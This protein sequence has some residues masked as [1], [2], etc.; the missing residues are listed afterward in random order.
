MIATAGRTAAAAGSVVAPA[1]AG[2]GMIAGAAWARPT[3]TALE[4]CERVE[5]E[6]I[7]SREATTGSE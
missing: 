1:V 7:Q 5:E 3:W 6:S 2:L 4:C